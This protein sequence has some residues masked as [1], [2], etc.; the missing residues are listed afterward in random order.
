MYCYMLVKVTTTLLDLWEFWELE[1][2]MMV[3][4]LLDLK[5]WVGIFMSFGFD[6]VQE[7]NKTHPGTHSSQKEFH[8]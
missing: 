1:K 6:F 2:L 7:W 5:F 3:K 4:N 8:L